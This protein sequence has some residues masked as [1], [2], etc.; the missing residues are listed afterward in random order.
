MRVKDNRLHNI[1][2]KQSKES[3]EPRTTDYITLLLDKVRN[4]PIPALPRTS[5]LRRV[6]SESAVHA[7]LSTLSL[8]FWRNPVR[9]PHCGLQRQSQVCFVL[10]ILTTTTILQALHP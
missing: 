10:E 3:S 9:I 7:S 4:L 5:S 6:P 2:A 1:V 8:D